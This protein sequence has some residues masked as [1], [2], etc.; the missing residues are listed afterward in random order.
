MIACPLLVGIL[1]SGQ[2]YKVNHP[3]QHEALQGDGG[4]VVP[5]SQAI[6]L[7]SID[8]GY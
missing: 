7:R 4:V 2:R 3:K 1:G 5:S 6:A 8:K